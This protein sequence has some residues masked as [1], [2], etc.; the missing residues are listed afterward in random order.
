V[1]AAEGIG[2]GVATSSPCWLLGMVTKARITWS[3]VAAS[4]IVAAISS[5]QEV[6]GLDE[7]GGGILGSHTDLQR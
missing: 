6:V 1:A 2:G 4:G 3:G 5:S 7:I